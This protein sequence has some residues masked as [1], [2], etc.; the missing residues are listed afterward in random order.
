MDS[1]KLYSVT[2]SSVNFVT[3]DPV[4]FATVDSVNASVVGSRYAPFALHILNA[5]EALGAVAM[6]SVAMDS[7]AMGSVACY[8]HDHDRRYRKVPHAPKSPKGGVIQATRRAKL[9]S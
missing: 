4:N 5:S 3:V 8:D 7:V 6:D 2:M 9:S 1:V